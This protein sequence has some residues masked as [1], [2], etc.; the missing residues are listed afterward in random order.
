MTQCFHFFF[1]FKW[2]TTD[3]CIWIFFFNKRVIRLYKISLKNKKC[4]FTFFSNRQPTAVEINKCARSELCV[5]HVWQN[6]SYLTSVLMPISKKWGNFSKSSKSASWRSGADDGGFGSRLGAS[7]TRRTALKK[8]LMQPNG[9]KKPWRDGMG[10]RAQLKQKKTRNEIRSF[11]SISFLGFVDLI[12]AR[13]S[14][15]N[16]WE[17]IQINQL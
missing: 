17:T 13:W 11:Y 4:C 16:D 7:G 2:Q 6:V 15:S 10:A 9:A 1:F 8:T 3:N 14:I 5:R 12:C